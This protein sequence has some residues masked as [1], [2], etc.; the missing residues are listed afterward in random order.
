MWV[1]TF[2]LGMMLGHFVSQWAS[3]KSLSFRMINQLAM[4]TADTKVKRLWRWMSCQKKPV[5]DHPHRRPPP[6]PQ[7]PQLEQLLSM[8][9]TLS[10]VASGSMNVGGMRGPSSGI[11][12]GIPHLTSSNA[13]PTRVPHRSTHSPHD[14]Q[15]SHHIT[16]R[17]PLRRPPSYLLPDEKSQIGQ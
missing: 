2:I 17:K 7:M 5:H 12:E 1:L 15:N 6:P 16:H 13:L 11:H 8:V 3:Y 4:A 10:Q 14:T 9:Q